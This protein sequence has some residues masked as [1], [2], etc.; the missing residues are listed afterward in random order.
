M[1]PL[2]NERKSTRPKSRELT[3]RESEPLRKVNPNDSLEIP[4]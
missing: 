4:K 2:E 3:V 1:V